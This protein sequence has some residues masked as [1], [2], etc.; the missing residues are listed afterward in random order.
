M[1]AWSGC[2]AG[3]SSSSSPRSSF[4]EARSRRSNSHQDLLP[5]VRRLNFG[6]LARN[7]RQHEHTGLF[8]HL[9][10]FSVTLVGRLQ[11]AGGKQSVARSQHEAAI[12]V[13][14][15]DHR[16]E[17]GSFARVSKDR[18][19]ER[20]QLAGLDRKWR[21]RGKVAPAFR[22]EGALQRMSLPSVMCRTP[23]SRMR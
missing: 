10:R 12:C 23:A 15:L 22:A 11:R 4:S 18:L 8:L 9:Q 2:P 3:P 6:E 7:L 21:S 1:F 13:H 17:G 16:G 14:A 19:L 5:R 20:F